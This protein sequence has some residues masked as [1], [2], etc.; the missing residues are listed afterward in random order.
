M[1]KSN[2][3]ALL[4]VEAR[5][6]EA[7]REGLNAHPKRLPPWLFYDEVGS[8]LF[9]AITEVPEYYLTRTERDIL[10]DHAGEMLAQAAQGARLRIV[11]LGAGS[12]DKTRLLLAAAVNRQGAVLY[13]PV[14]VSSSA[15]EAA[16]VR[17]EGEIPGV[18]VAPLQM[19]YTHGLDLDP[20]D[21][22][23]HR[24]IL[25]IGSSIGNFEPL[26]ALELLRRYARG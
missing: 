24:L 1:T 12:A 22:G 17:I 13:E 4:P 16:R 18:R 26:Q 9:D 20:V 7:V 5:V 14:D 10:T 3:V 21:A 2:A 6:A 19:D 25:Y 15:L 23:E 8:Q 11:E